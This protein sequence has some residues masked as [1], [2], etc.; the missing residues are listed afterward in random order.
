M[1]FRIR[2]MPPIE[3]EGRS[4]AGTGRSDRSVIRPATPEPTSYPQD[5]SPAAPIISQHEP[6]A[7]GSVFRPRARRVGLREV[8]A[9][10]RGVHIQRHRPH[11]GVSTSTRPLPTLRLAYRGRWMALKW[12]SAV[13]FDAVAASEFSVDGHDPTAIPCSPTAIPCRRRAHGGGWRPI[14]SHPTRGRRAW[15]RGSGDRTRAPPQDRSVG[16]RGPARRRARSTPDPGRRG[17]APGVRRASGRASAYGHIGR[18]ERQPVA[19]SR[20]RVGARKGGR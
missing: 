10:G 16:H 18:T 13:A 9:E 5:A 17:P 15:S 12:G 19:V 1:S 7:R 14:P 6:G 4:P 20:D 2:V 11:P 3:S 8:D